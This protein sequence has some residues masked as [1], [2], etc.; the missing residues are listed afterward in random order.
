MS[1]TDLK[2]ELEKLLSEDLSNRQSLQE[3]RRSVFLS[4]ETSKK[5][6]E[7]IEEKESEILGLRSTV[8]QKQHALETKEDEIVKAQALLQAER[9]NFESSKQNLLAEIEDLKN[10]IAELRSGQDEANNLREETSKLSIENN[11]FAGKI[12]E[13]IFHIDEQ[14][15][16]QEKLEKEIASL[17]DSL[18]KSNAEKNQMELD[19]SGSN[20]KEAD[21]NALNEDLESTKSKVILLQTQLM[22]AYELIDVQNKAAAEAQ[23]QF[24]VYQGEISF[25]LEKL[26]EEKDLLIKDNAELIAEMSG[27]TLEN[28]DLFAEQKSLSAQVKE[29]QAQNEEFAD[30]LS[31]L[32]SKEQMIISLTEERTALALRVEELSNVPAV[33]ENAYNEQ[34]DFLNKELSNIS[35]QLEET[36][37]ASKLKIEALEFEK[38]NLML[39]IQD[40][41]NQVSENTAGVE[42]SVSDSAPNADDAF[43]DKLFKQIDLLNDEK[44]LIQTENEEAHDS[45]KDLQLKCAELTQVIENQ[46]NTISNLEETNKEIKLAQSL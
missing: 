28:D 38:N 35:A 18:K 9:E 29:L 33:D 2:Q 17:K 11:H 1:Y 23:N 3:M 20:A 43:I 12:R 22:T 27:I 19:L 5:S 8:S 34:I 25:C 46:K 36:G 4:T 6:T 39:K 13:L 31:E 7:L 42:N 44:L 41:E 40:L 16:A 45:V 26:H 21:I 15:T 32:R 30:S 14:N 10:V 24:Q 37:S